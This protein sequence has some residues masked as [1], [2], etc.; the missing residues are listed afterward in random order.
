[1][2]L[3]VA[4]GLAAVLL[5]R[6]RSESR[7]A[8]LIGFWVERT[9]NSTL[10]LTLASD[11]TFSAVGAPLD[12]ECKRDVYD[13]PSLG[14]LTWGKGRWAFDPQT[15]HLKLNYDPP[16]D[17]RC[18]VRRLPD[19]VVDASM[20]ETDLLLY[21]DG[22]EHIASR[23]RLSKPRPPPPPSAASFASNQ[24]ECFRAEGRWDRVCMSQQYTCLTRYRDAG[25]ACTDSS[26]CQGKCLVDMTVTCVRGAECTDPPRPEPGQPFT[27][28]CQ[29]D[30]EH[31]G[32]FIEIRK[33][34]AEPGYSI[35]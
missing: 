8:E 28:Q 4:A 18:K 12:H 1:M 32:S 6:G 14:W 30:D 2:G 26:Q 27:G 24:V 9:N 10:R 35:D 19:L 11:H 23:I 22:P 34:R 7:D 3:L 13:H 5:V 16:A 33:G 29:R 15:L 31:C 17:P 25:K 20:G 21:P